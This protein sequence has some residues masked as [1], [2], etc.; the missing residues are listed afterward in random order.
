MRL[1]EFINEC[2]R[3]MLMPKDEF[4]KLRSELSA[5]EAK[6]EELTSTNTGSPKLPPCSLCVPGVLRDSWHK[7][8]YRLCPY[9]GR[10]L[11]ADA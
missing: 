10:Q 6:V 5:L 1:I 9:C 11:R 3:G 4:D 7:K 2:E 8:S